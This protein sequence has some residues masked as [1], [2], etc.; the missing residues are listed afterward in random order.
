MS[1]VMASA[2]L[3]SIALPCQYYTRDMPPLNAE[4]PASFMF[5]EA[6]N[7]SQNATPVLSRNQNPYNLE[8]AKRSKHFKFM[9]LRNN[10]NGT[11]VR[12]LWRHDRSSNAMRSH[13]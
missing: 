13:P 4:Y 2:N 9:D 7:R 6:D 12:S 1:I 11:G 10:L 5:N 3:L 8:R